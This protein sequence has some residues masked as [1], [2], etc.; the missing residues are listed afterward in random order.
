MNNPTEPSAPANLPPP[1]PLTPEQKQ[2]Q[3]IEVASFLAGVKGS[4]T[5]LSKKAVDGSTLRQVD[6]LDLAKI[7]KELDRANNV[8][9]NT[10]QPVQHAVQS[11]PQVFQ[12]PLVQEDSNQL[13]F[14]F[15]KKVSLDDIFN[16]IDDTY[17]KL[18]SLEDQVH[19]I[20]NILEE[21]KSI[22]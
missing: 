7:A 12:Q 14:Q 19:K 16:K 18:I 1:A 5:E 17:R 20:K 13:T 2:N 8:P 21:K 15:D 10:A 3:L 4:L 11:Q 6:N 9:V 22:L